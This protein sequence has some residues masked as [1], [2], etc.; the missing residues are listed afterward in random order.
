MKLEEYEKV[1]GLTY[2]EYCDYLQAK[3]GIG[4]SDY[5]T[6]SWNKNGK[7]SR[8]KEG[9]VV[10]HKF[11]E[12]V[13]TLYRKGNAINY[14][15]EWQLAKNIVYCDYLEHLFLHILICEDQA[16]DKNPDE[17]VGIGGVINFIVPELN[18]VYSGWETSQDWKK[19]AYS[20]ILDDKDV[21]MRLL[22]RFKANCRYPVYAEKY[23]YCSYH[24]KYKTWSTAQNKN[25]FD[26]I[27]NL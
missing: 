21:Y 17:V 13:L 4:R 16:K 22:K 19:K 9:L 25:L 18:D 3:Y 5:M 14:P 7:V 26:E 11:E 12:R 27:K 20:L 24:A 8:S 2:R 15:F 10:H 1:K 6:K 23:L